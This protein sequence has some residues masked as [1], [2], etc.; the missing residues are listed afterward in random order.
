MGPTTAPA[1]DKNPGQLAVVHEE[2]LPPGAGAKDPKD[3]AFALPI[4]PG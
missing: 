4:K 3:F 2:V 1:D